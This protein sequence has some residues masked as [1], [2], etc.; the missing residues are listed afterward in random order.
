MSSSYVS[1]CT[2][3]LEAIVAREGGLTI[4]IRSNYEEIAK[5]YRKDYPLAV[6][7]AGAIALNRA[8]AKA[9][10]LTVRMVAKRMGVPQKFVRERVK[11]SRA[12][13]FKLRTNLQ[14]KGRPLNVAR[15][16]ARQ[17]KGGV[18]HKAWKGGSTGF[19]KGA[20]LVK[21]KNPKSSLTEFVA[22]RP[23]GGRKMKG[24]WGP[25]PPQEFVGHTKGNDEGVRPE[26]AKM[27]QQFFVELYPRELERQIQI[28]NGKIKP[29]RGARSIHG[30]SLRL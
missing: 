14:M 10:T 28:A 13:K 20:F 16:G 5:V 9:R 3:A 29:N 8:M 7:S 24:V 12:W 4:D 15:F 2:L 25:W 26:V 19:L 23:G 22:H 17:L 30:K 1:L 18:K 11:V 6:K 21:I 27:A